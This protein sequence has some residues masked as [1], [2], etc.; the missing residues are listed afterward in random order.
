[1]KMSESGS[2]CRRLC[3]PRR[4]SELPR[5]AKLRVHARL[6]SHLKASG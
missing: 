5:L 1:M 4:I 3:I 2:I 6:N